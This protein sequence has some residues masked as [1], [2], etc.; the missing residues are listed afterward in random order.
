MILNHGSR[1]EKVLAFN[2]RVL[3]PDHPDIADSMSRLAYTYGEVG[4]ARD[5]LPLQEGVSGFIA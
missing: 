5:A 2:R 3:P 1:K 4:R